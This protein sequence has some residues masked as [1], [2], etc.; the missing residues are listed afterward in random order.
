MVNNWQWI[1]LPCDFSQWGLLN[2]SSQNLQLTQMICLIAVLLVAM[3]DRKTIGQRIREISCIF[4][5][6]LLDI[7]KWK[8]FFDIVFLYPRNMCCSENTPLSTLACSWTTHPLY[9]I[10]PA[11]LGPQ[12]SQLLTVIDLTQVWREDKLIDLV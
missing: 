2:F 8:F 5:T 12:M 11:S 9:S 3:N 4:C 10:L 7:L 6:A 1:V